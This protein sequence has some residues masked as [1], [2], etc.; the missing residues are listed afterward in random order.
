MAMLLTLATHAGTVQ[1]AELSG[2]ILDPQG[3]VVAGARLYLFDRDAGTQHQATTRM[4]GTYSFPN[5]A[6][7]AYLLQGETPDGS[8]TAVR[9]LDVAGNST[10][11][12]HLSVS[13][14]KTSIVVTASSTPVA[15]D[16]VAKA[17]DVV[18][19]QEISLRT[20]FSL[21]EAVR[22]LPGVRIQQLRGPGSFVTI[23]TRGLRNFDTALLVDG[24]RFRDAASTQGDAT[25]FLQDMTLIDADRVEMLRGSGSSLYGSHAMA[26]VINVTSRR[27]GGRPHGEIRAEG[28]GLGMLRGVARAAGGLGNDRF[29]Y[30][31]GLSHLNVTRGYRSGSPF[32]NTAVQGS[33][34]FLPKPGLVIAARVWGS[35][36]FRTLVENPAFP[37]SVVANFPSS[38]SVPA[39]PLR[40]SQLALLERG[41]PYHAGNATFVPDQIDPDSRNS[42]AFLISAFSLSHDISPRSSYRL[43]F[44]SVETRRKYQDGPAGPGAFDPPVSNDS[45]F[46]GR[47][48]TF[49]ARTDHRIGGSHL[50]NLGYEFEHETYSNR[51]TDESPSPIESTTEIDQANHAVFAQ[52]QI[53]LL[54]GSLHV[55]L[56]ARA[57]RFVL[58]SPV[59]SGAVGPYGNVV[60]ASSQ[61]S[62][63]GD[64]ALAYFVK[65][66]GTK[67]RSH[68]GTG[69]RAPSLYERFGGSFSSYSGSFNYWG[70]PRLAP[71]SSM[72][73]DLGIDQWLFDSK[74][75]LS[76]TYF[77][78]NLS[79]TIV[80]DFANFPA[81]DEFGR[82]G[83]YRNTGGGIGRGVEFSAQVAP[84]SST[85]LRGSYT[86]AN[87]ESRTPT[88]GP[89]FFDIPGMSAS[90]Y[91]VAATQWIGNRIALTFDMFA[92]SDYILSP[93]GALGRK[94]IFGGPVKADVVVRYD[95]PVGDSKTLEFYGKVENVFNHDYYEDGFGSPGAWAIGG[96][97]FRY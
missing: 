76:G 81:N 49:L 36:S 4:D 97:R 88:I 24:M 16:G 14:S 57:Q 58:G 33:A 6:A 23:Q 78:T 94:M 79:E 86:Y 83:G 82:F 75:R 61:S 2:R 11:D 15:Q 39:R 71:E 28:G 69:F 20:E 53:R 93:Y 17:L 21:A 12:L 44:N 18:G 8:L 87:S 38:G 72:A 65:A 3:A 91:T 66:S 60:S 73:A 22:N 45:R 64:V 9:E 90:V 42:S 84:S 48:H 40:V 30:S 74:L 77:Y 52:D 63:I 96:L 59:Y 43:A 89:N 19:S 95:L 46:N 37:A 70:D 80:F 55:G 5:L 41:D 67:F 54:D 27:G 47:T 32:R 26:G 7:R 1:A 13:A 25:V 51:N 29:Q 92:A 50:A 85:N 31:G 62:F 10:F 35:D 56:S 68:W 34:R